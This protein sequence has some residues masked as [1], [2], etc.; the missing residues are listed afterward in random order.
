[1]QNSMLHVLETHL[2]WL[3]TINDD[4]ID[5]K[6]PGQSDYSRIAVVRD[7]IRRMGGYELKKI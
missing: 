7:G 4:G 5:Q 1:M 2:R 3:G 6:D